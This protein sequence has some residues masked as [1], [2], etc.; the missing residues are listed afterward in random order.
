MSDRIRVVVDVPVKGGMPP[1]KV[2]RKIKEN[3][4]NSTRT[5]FR[6]ED[7]AVGQ[8]ESFVHVH[9]HDARHD[10]CQTCWALCRDRLGN[11]DDD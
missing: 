7:V 4:V 11:F 1:N 6:T 3:V 8:S 10:D 5:A 2:I 9:E